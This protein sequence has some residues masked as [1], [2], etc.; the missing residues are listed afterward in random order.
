MPHAP[1]GWLV[2]SVLDPPLV[3][4]ANTDS[5]FCRSSPVQDGQLGVCPWRVRYSK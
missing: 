5:S 1:T 3:F 2:A 4:T